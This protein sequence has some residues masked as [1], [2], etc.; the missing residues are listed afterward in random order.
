MIAKRKPKLAIIDSHALIHRAYHALPPMSTRQGVPTNAA[1][2]F[3]TMLLK[4]FSTLKPTHVVA[5]FDM[6]GPTFRHEIFKDYKAHRGALEDDLISQFDLVREVVRAF[7]IPV[8]EKQGFEA[9][10]IIGTVTE[11]INDGVKK[12]I[13]TGDMDT[14]QLV[15]DDTSVFTL[16]RGISDTVL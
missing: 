2:G 13:I 14:L 9:D 12:V 11:R 1:L 3:T 6:K 5:A 4:M 8:L 7:N 10:D 15:D 16:K